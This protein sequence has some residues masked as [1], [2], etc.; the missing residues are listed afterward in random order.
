MYNAKY[1]ICVY[2]SVYYSIHAS[3][4]YVFLNVWSCGIAV[5]SCLL[6]EVQ[7][8]LNTPH[9]AVKNTSSLCFLIFSNTWSSKFRN[10]ISRKSHRSS[11]PFQNH[12]VH[13]R[14]ECLPDYSA[15]WIL[16]TSKTSET[17]KLTRNAYSGRCVGT[18]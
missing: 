14:V 8:L 7:L 2:Y 10:S 3:I 11:L 18:H 16:K 1:N 17:R 4:Q 6:K 5:L 9:L 12:L 13:K 15:K